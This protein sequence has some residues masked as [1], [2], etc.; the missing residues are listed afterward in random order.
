MPMTPRKNNTPSAAPVFVD[1]IFESPLWAKSRLSARRRV[2]DILNAVWPM[3]PKRPAR[4]FPELTVTLM[5][6]TAIKILNRDYRGKNKPT[7]VLSFPMFN[8]L[9]EIPSGAGHI[10]LGDIMIA[11]E[12]IRRE[13]DEQEK[14]LSD[15]FTHMLVHG[16]LHLLGYDHMT[17]KEAEEM[18]SLEIRILKKFSVANPYV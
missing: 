1:V 18:E 5:D 2:N 8:S 4:V 9:G 16:F 10:P 11:F 7:N 6:D 14:S 15:H 12:T 17:D 3:V 13:A